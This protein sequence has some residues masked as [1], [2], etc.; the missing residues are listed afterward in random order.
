V[1]AQASDKRIFK[2]EE[3]LNAGAEVKPDLKECP[4]IFGVK[5]YL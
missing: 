4:V 3:F 2:D 1:I 5:E